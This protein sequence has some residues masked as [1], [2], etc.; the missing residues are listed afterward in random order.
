MKEKGEEKEYFGHVATRNQMIM[1]I[2]HLK[3]QTIII[4]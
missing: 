3:N 4:V 1:N 2:S